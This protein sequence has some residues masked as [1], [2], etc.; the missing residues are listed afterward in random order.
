MNTRFLFGAVALWAVVGA[1]IQPLSAQEAG[2]STILAVVVDAESHKPVSGVTVSVVDGPTRVTDKLG[3]AV[4]LNLPAGVHVLEAENLGYATRRDSV[5]LVPRRPVRVELPLTPEAL[6]LEGITVSVSPLEP[7]ARL[8]P[9]LEH[10]ARGRGDILLRQDIERMGNPPLP[11]LLDRVQ[12]IRLVRIEGFNTYM[13]PIIRGA[14]DLNGRLC[15]P[16]LIMDG[17]EID[18]NEDPESAVMLSALSGHEVEAIEV[19]AS[20]GEV[21]AD[22][23]VNRSRC[24][25]IAVWTR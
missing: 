20:A 4:F 21:P 19:Y 2:T 22:F 15:A 1:T 11:N 10:L 24:G 5:F 23:H 17:H 8:S 9:V 7:T 14:R 18:L 16:V 13:V 12:G 3:R 25:V 6:E